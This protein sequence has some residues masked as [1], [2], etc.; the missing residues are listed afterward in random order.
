M[1]RFCTLPLATA[2]VAL[3]IMA[4]PSGQ[5]PPLAPGPASPVSLQ[6]SI[7]QDDGTPVRNITRDSI[8]VLVDGESRSI[9]SFLPSTRPVSVVLLLD[10][11]ASMRMGGL[12]SNI[13]LQRAVEQWLPYTLKPGD[14]ARVGTIAKR[15]F[16]SDRF[17]SNPR[18]LVEA[19]FVVRSVPATETNGPSPIW[20]AIDNAIAALES[21][22]NSRAVLVLTD[23][24][25]TGNRKGLREVGERALAASTSVHFIGERDVPT[26][27]TQISGDQAHVIPS[28]GP[29][30]LAEL[31]G[32]SYES[33][34]RFPWSDPGPIFA[35]V[36]DRL[37]H[38]YTLV[39]TPA[40]ADG[41][42]HNIDIKVRPVSLTVRA[43]K[44]FIASR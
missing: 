42:S 21:E 14:R 9:T 39:F 11:S 16:L 12:S 36:M 19:G 43:R 24:R 7:E 3:G 32:G 29:R 18:D 4:H 28:L 35:R 1:M 37:H 23:G 13:V 25:A 15:L 20:D 38:T 8:E 6:V 5:Q 10:V 34:K 27:I 30:W 26:A 40:S 17:T 22:D 41:K 33:D 31:T 44:Q 2:A